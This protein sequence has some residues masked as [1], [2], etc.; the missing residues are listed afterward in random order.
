MDAETETKT[1]KEA[2]VEDD[3][4]V[5]SSDLSSESST[6]SES[7]EVSD[8]QDSILS[9]EED[10]KAEEEATEPDIDE[11]ES[12]K[13]EG[14]DGKYHYIQICPMCGGYDCKRAGPTLITRYGRAVY[15]PEPLC[16]EETSEEE[17]EI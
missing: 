2:S 4:S 3:S 8:E 1:S 10:K 11:A 16:L 5:H 14:D 12:E 17:E 15:R 13:E 9:F 7:S 6:E